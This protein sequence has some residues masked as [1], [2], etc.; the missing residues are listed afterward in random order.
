MDDKK[1]IDLYPYRVVDNDVSFLLFRRAKGKIYEGQWR[2]IGGK[3]KPQE[4]YWKAALRELR[5]ETNLVPKHFWTIPSINQFYEHT[6]DK[7]LSIPAFAAEIN[8]DEIIKL[9]DEH[10]EFR[11]IKPK[12]AST[13]IKWPEQIRLIELTNKLITS[14]KILDDWRVPI[15]SS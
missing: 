4:T 6:S 3:V 10:T 11:W 1:L 13:Y 14:N 5:E 8:P 2:M 15:S 12:D 7:I 9:D